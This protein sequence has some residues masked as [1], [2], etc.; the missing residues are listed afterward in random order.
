MR[1]YFFD[2][3]QAGVDEFGQPIYDR[4]YGASNFCVDYFSPLFN[5]GGVFMHVDSEACLVTVAGAPPQY[6]LVINKGFLDVNGYRGICDGDDVFPVFALPDG[7]YRVI[8]RLNVSEGVRAFSPELIRGSA[9]EYPE[10][11]RSGNI[12]DM[13]FANVQ[14]DKG[15]PVVVEDTRHDEELCGQLKFALALPLPARPTYYPPFVLPEELWLYANFPEALNQQQIDLVESNPYLMESWQA[16]RIATHTKDISNPHETSQSSLIIDSRLQ[17]WPEGTT[18]T[19][20]N[21]KY[22]SALMKCSG[23]GTVSRATEYG[24][25]TITGTI[26]VRY[27]FENII[28]AG[29]D[30]KTVTLSYSKNGVV[31]TETFIANLTNCPVDGQGRRAFQLTLTNCTLD[32]VKMEEGNKATPLSAQN[33]DFEALRVD[34]YFQKCG[35]IARVHQVNQNNIYA[36]IGL[37]AEMRIV[38][39]FINETLV[40]ATIA[41][42]VV[43][44]FT[45]SRHGDTT[46]LLC[47]ITASKSSH[48]LSDGLI[49]G[50]FS[51]DARL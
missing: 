13:C 17:N 45:F 25:M 5:G 40:V 46:T 11:V 30:G 2:A 20:P 14:M 49:S 51:L 38:S 12:H 29:I 24:G 9:T 44:D 26:A 36:G 35:T 21:N 43:P 6:E 7:Y 22:T 48:G 28:F 27:I 34:R 39:T 31:E 1:G 19:N 47:R 3:H 15:V 41:G 10:I 37:R 23:T 4:E 16:S 33:T 50:K 42:N 32:W 18:F 8:A